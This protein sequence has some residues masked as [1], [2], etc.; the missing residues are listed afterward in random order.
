[1]APPPPSSDT[2]QPGAT[3]GL[4]RFKTHSLAA[5]LLRSHMTV[6]AIG[7]TMLGLIL[8]FT[9]YM[10]AR[11]A[12]LAQV[13]AP[14]AQA[15]RNVLEGLERSLANLRGWVLIEDTQFSS[16]R[17]LAWSQQIE[18]ALARLEVLIRDSTPAEQQ[19]IAEAKIL[20]SELQ[21]VQWWIEDVAQTP[22]NEPARDLLENRLQPVMDE[23]YDS[24]TALID[25]EK[26]AGETGRPNRILAAMADFRGFFTRSQATLGN[27]L[28]SGAGAHQR[29]F[30]SQVDVARARL[31]DL[32]GDAA[33]L[34]PEQRVHL[35]RIELQLPYY[36][37]VSEET[38]TRRN[39]PDWN[40]ARSLLRD[41]A[42]PRARQA[43][44]LLTVLAEE[45]SQKVT[46]D[47]G[48]LEKLGNAAIG[49]SG[50]CF[51]GMATAA[52]FV[53]RRGASRLMQPIG[54]LSEATRKMAAGEWTE[55]IPVVSDDELGDLTVSFNR[56]RSSL[57]EAEQALKGREE[58]SRTV[59]E[60]SPSGMI[61]TDQ[62]GTIMMLN[63]RAATLFGYTREELL[64]QPIEI[65]VPDSARRHHYELRDGY[66]KHPEVRAMG[67]GR[68]L[69][70]RRKDGS[71]IPIEIGLNPI[72]TDE[73]VRVLAGII[74][75]TERK[76]VEK[77]L[78]WQ[79]A[80]ARL[81]HRSVALASE[82]ANFEDALQR[83]IDEVCEE[84][85]WSVGHVY[86]PDQDGR[87][88][89]STRIWHLQ[90]KDAHQEFRK[91]TE[92]TSFARGLGLP[93]RILE[94]GEPHWIVDVLQDPNFPRAKACR[95]LG[96]TSAFGFPVKIQD[97]TVAV[98]EFFTEEKLEPD[99]NLLTLADSVGNQVGRVL[100]RQRAQED[101]RIAKEAAEAAAQ[102]KSEFLANMSHE[103][104]TPMNGI[105]G[106]T[107]L[108]L[109]TSLSKDQQEYLNLVNQSADSLLT[110][111]NDILDFSKIEAGKLELDH[112]DFDL[113]DS[114][115][116]TLHTLG[117]RAAEKGIELAYQVQSNVPDC[118]VG[119]LG[120]LRQIIV[121]LVGNALKFTH[122]GEV[123]VDVQLE[124]QTSDQASL[125]FLI[126]DTG[127]G[128][129]PEKQKT[130]FESFTQAESATT[131]TYGGTGLGLTISRQLVELMMGRMWLQSEPGKGSTFHFTALLG[132][133]SEKPSA[134]R[135]SPETLNGLPVLV[136][137]D[138]D[139]NRRIL[140]EMLRNWEMSPAV[141]SGG[142]EALEK[143]ETASNSENPFRLI[144]LDVMMPE[145]DGPE[146]AQ[147][148]Q[149]R[150]GENA[151]K[152]LILSS[153]GHQAPKDIIASLGVDRILTKP[154]KQSDLLDAIT[155]LFGTATRDDQGAEETIETRP[156]HVPPM[157]VLLA[158]DGR[159]NQMVAI[160]L[161]E[162]RG[163][164]VVLATNGRQALGTLEHE[165]F[166][167]VLMDVQMPEMDGYEAT[168]AIREKEKSAGGHIPIIA[169][170]AN[171]MKGD[172]EKC[173]EAGMDDYVAKPV[174]S[175][176]L[177]TTLEK[178]AAAAREGDVPVAANAGA[179]PP[180]EEVFDQRDFEAQAG[181]GDLMRELIDIFDEES[182]EM[183]ARIET[184]SEK[185]D[186]KALHEAAHALK[187]MIGNYGA[188]QAFDKAKE[189]DSLAR[190]GNLARARAE[191][192]R[193][194]ASID[195]LRQALRN[196][197][198]R[199][200][201]QNAGTE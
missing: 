94:S 154:V 22:G 153:A 105:I 173:L 82:G 51:I 100:E 50:L 166:D 123:L 18:P 164:S 10:R 97:Q 78:A 57:A 199:I 43:G 35:E 23:I 139:T 171:A 177:F 61:M 81:L 148:V 31:A 64:G 4:E 37:A 184:A 62:N 143:L 77:L 136:V 129:P 172:R 132:L 193:L 25:L 93:G 124:S 83:C 157:K 72:Q 68:D 152:I 95:D 198:E 104:R 187:G 12:R 70:G 74:D 179:T 113:R 162:D 117:F 189:I 87:S 168:G 36:L 133:G 114:I 20:L 60:S 165:N 185:G 34:S 32:A 6:A 125:H 69:S 85:G 197:R 130:I 167:A 110:V 27:L 102:A 52:W 46:E 180:S 149:D 116:D 13:D 109:E 119:D 56:M 195:R 146:V 178:Y 147:R 89:E 29:A 141:A 160:R 150:F 15:S 176:E 71:L 16:S 86:L 115:G 131:R 75:L 161:L 194:Q 80:E 28:Q 49:L 53:S 120:R 24:I 151:P 112:H 5:R 138:N 186:A 41:E 190:E 192:P 14:M 144:L 134:A 137:D 191:I 1:M 47:A 111:I 3:A 9:F 79:A 103:I 90:D 140:G 99:E 54:K 196:F 45:S 59:I 170:T 44:A 91:V 63:R 155:R 48:R 11:T 88:L 42:V 30:R 174:R 159:V 65:L 40:I 158:E 98:L 76:R 142:T 26:L 188:R 8:L 92:Q 73:G 96:L 84:I 200:P 163:H 122:E 39:A 17:R 101:L 169:M 19:S 67:A 38:I 201:G 118:L 183:L 58:E 128:I 156:H 135:I 121:N 175:H 66:M 182:G 7:L 181:D 145:M 108:L 55:D 33:I 107:E 21:E 2:G 127:I 106:M 126:K